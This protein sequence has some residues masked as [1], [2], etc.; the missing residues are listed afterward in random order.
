MSILVISVLCLT[1][2][3]TSFLSGIFGMAGG[4]IMI[5][6]LLALLPLPDAMLLHGVTQMASNGWR[7]LLWWR[8]VRLGPVLAY[9]GGC[10]LALLAWSFWRY[11]PGKPLALLLL[12][13]TPFLARAL[14]ERLKP[15]P[16]SLV[17]GTLYGALCMTLILLTGIAGPL[18]DTYFLGGR[19]DRR[20]I[21]ATKAVC[22]TFGHAA[23]IVYF[24]TLIDQ[25]ATL[26]PVVAT[27]SIAAT[28]LG[29]VLAAR[30]LEAMT[31]KQYRAWANRI[32]TAI[33][34]YYVAYGAYL[35][36]LA[37]ALVH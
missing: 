13:A 11:V 21:V 35:M 16:E 26:Q 20:E 36:L 15:D 17:H 31:D 18:V 30:V 34:G 24:G 9:S 10:A 22:Q 3:G 28:M 6:V 8:Y 5:G 12:G 2:V 1:M 33:A 19:L 7:G 27:L 32:I 25:V 37:P 29:T 23:K 14:P 4:M